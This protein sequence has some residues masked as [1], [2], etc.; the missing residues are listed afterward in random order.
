[1]EG[2][3]LPK[4]SYFLHKPLGDGLFLVRRITDG[5]VLLGQPLGPSPGDDEDDGLRS[6]ASLLNHENL[7]SIHDELV[8]IPVSFPS[9]QGGQQRNISNS[10]D[11]DDVVVVVVSDRLPADA[12]LGLPRRRHTA[13]RAR[14]LRPP[15]GNRSSSSGG[16]GFMPESFVWHVAIGLLR[17]LQ[18]LHGGDTGD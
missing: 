8:N 13:G 3:N 18:W 6:A 15:G 1:M 16:G 14:R 11:D 12:S 5:E 10:C 17:A 7:I 4:S 9:N 2:P